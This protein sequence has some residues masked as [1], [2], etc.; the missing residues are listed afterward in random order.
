MLFYGLQRY[1]K[2]SC[3]SKKLPDICLTFYCQVLVS[4]LMVSLYALL[5]SDSIFRFECCSMTG[6]SLLMSV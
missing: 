6:F 2:M 1:D 3:Q 5:R 4:Y